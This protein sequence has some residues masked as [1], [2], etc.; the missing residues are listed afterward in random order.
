MSEQAAIHVLLVEDNATDALL[1]QETLADVRGVAF[2]L[3]IVERLGDALLCLQAKAFDVI[4]LDLGLPDSSGAATFQQLL[5]R[6]PGVPVL[7]LTGLED[8]EVGLA[9][10]QEG[11]QDYLV[12]NQLQA[13][14]LGRAIRYA[15]ERQRT[16]AALLESEERLSAIINSPMDGIITIDEEQ[17]ITLFNPAAEELFG[18]R[19]EEAV[20]H[21]LE[22]FIPKRFCL[23]HREHM[24][25]Y[26]QAD[27]AAKEMGELRLISGLRADG[28]EFPMEASVAQIE[29][30]GQ[31]LFTV[32]L[33]DL[34]E[35]LRSQE[36]LRESEERLQTVIENLTEGLIIANHTGRLLHWNRAG[37]Q[38]HGLQSIEEAPS[39]MQELEIIFEVSSLDGHRL[40]FD[41]WPLPRVL[42]GEPLRNVDL[43]IR[44]LDKPW[45]RIFSYGGAL[46]REPNGNQLAFLTITD[47][48]ARKHA[49]DKIREGERLY[50]Q[51]VDALPVAV[52]TTDA[53]GYVT[54]YNEAA[55]ELWGRPAEIGK[56]R[57][58]GSHRSFITD[59]SSL[60]FDQ[61][62]MAVA[63]KEG[64]ALRGIEGVAERPDGSR[65]A[66]MAHP[67]SLHD[68]S[69]KLL[70]G[71]NVLVDISERKRAEERLREGEERY[72]SLVLATSQIVW[73]ADA[74]GN[75]VEATNAEIFPQRG[76]MLYAWGWLD[77]IHPDDW[78]GVLSRWQE[79][80][81]KRTPLF[82]EYRQLNADGNYHY[83]EAR[84]V[85][86]FDESGQVREW[87]GT[88]T[89][90]SGRKRA[91][92]RLVTQEAISRVLADSDSLA[93]AAPGVIQAL[94]QSEGWDFGE[95]WELDKRADVM[96]FVDGWHT[97]NAAL[98]EM[99]TKGRH[100][101]YGLGEGAPGQVWLQGKPQLIPLVPAKSIF[102]RAALAVDAGYDMV[103]GFPI[104]LGNKVTGVLICMAHN[105]QEADQGLLD[106]LDAIGKQIGQFTE[107]KRI[108]EEV[109]RFVSYSPAVIYALRLADDRFVHTWTS[110]NVFD[111]TGYLAQESIGTDWWIANIHPED[112]ERVLAAHALPYEQEH[113]L[114]EFRFRRKDGDYL[115]VRDEKR[116]LRDRE[117]K[118]A[119]VIGSWSDVSERRQLEEQLRQ[120][121]KMEAIGQLAGGIAHDFN[122]LLTVI[123]GFGDLLLR[124]LPSNDTNRPLVENIQHAG[125]RAA[126]LTRQLLAFSR[127][128]VMELKVMSL[129]DVVVHIE[130]ILQ[131]LIGENILLTTALAPSLPSVKVDPGQIEQVIIN[132]AVNARDAMPQGGRLTI[133]TRDVVFDEDYCRI[134][135]DAK[136]GRYIQLA[137]S[138]S[139]LGM[140]AEVKARIFE[141]F[142]TTKGIGKGTGLGLAT[143]FGII[144][145]SGGLIEV[146]S[147]VGVGT[148][149]KIFF[150]AIAEH[151]MA[152]SEQQS[153][154]VQR[155]HETV[156]LVED[157]SEVRKIAKLVLEMNGY[158]VLESDNG[159]N[160]IQI[161]E[162]YPETIHLLITDI[163]MPEMGGRQLAQHLQAQDPE[164]KVIFM[165]GYIDDAVVRHG[166]ID[167]N[168][169]FLQK[170][171]SPNVLARRVREVLDGK[172]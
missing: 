96:R 23:L 49:E 45:E 92:R 163:V 107:R 74:E 158:H 97:P 3:T 15:I 80:M 11:A 13:P 50:H 169:T 59:G 62:P 76:E 54:L 159:R 112:R 86:V 32:I 126:S 48:T 113:Q 88:A 35:R 128:Q 60:P 114:L 138:D 14:L 137:I 39:K 57:W 42:R 40:P 7:V 12:K 127:K 140:T 166:I 145:Q 152:A 70:G 20:G 105:L 43:R 154:N 78:E 168:E 9:A 4:L 63:L 109:Q 85:P 147:E 19:A 68:E 27:G 94:C 1:L 150:P 134:R 26:G 71:V 24:R 151:E 37:L 10:L 131:R 34:S 16:A 69:G 67:T 90:I 139:G 2:D 98:A 143:V 162:Q 130:K 108:Q 118:A 117:G 102:P 104:L 25:A 170:P 29:V 47:I 33:R 8:E 171:F 115:W 141:P 142:F 172:G 132:L 73:R 160:A 21:L 103:I 61:S 136:A 124:S 52:Y 99:V 93:D 55:I 41:Q 120:S 165:S 51:L 100:R 6:I 146:Y 161:A 22:R 156:L 101:V 17:R 82:F 72:R 133:E 64:R 144:K 148:V 87:I 38:M 58:C 106:T 119:E 149:F 129:N 65:V 75:L 110:E 89:N 116:L 44:R 135:P 31:K 56:D 95:I 167:A 28:T 30:G 125:D 83:Y 66:Y 5:R 81:E 79:A 121:Q 77:S 46:V 84:G 157:E 18:W 123:M 53:E 111:L 91:E 122:N 155:G 153:I 164:L 36:A